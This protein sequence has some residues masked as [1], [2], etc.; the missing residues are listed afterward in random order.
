M[1]K[2]SADYIFPITS[3]PIKNGVV[4]VDEHGFILNVSEASTSDNVDRYEGIICPGFVNTHCHLELSHMRSQVSEQLGMGG[5]IKEIISKRDSFSE[6]E[7]KKAIEIAEAEMIT[8]GIVAVGDISNEALTFEQKAKGNIKYH[9]FIE[10]FDLHP[11]KAKDVFERAIKHRDKLS[12][13]S[14][15]NFQLATS[16]VPHAPYTVTD[17]LFKL[18]AQEAIKSNSI[19]CIHNQESLA[20]SEFYM[21]H[22]GTIAESFT[23]MGIDLSYFPQTGLNSLQTIFPKLPLSQKIL[24]VH[25]TYTT[26]EDIVFAQNSKL[27]T[28]DLYWCT[29]PNANL[30]IENKL[31]NY[32]IFLKHN[33]TVTIGT[34]SLA[35]NKRLSVLDELK[36][37]TKHYPKI[38]LETLLLWAT[39]NGA[40]YLG[41][42]QLGSIEKGKQPGLNLLSNIENGALTN[43]TEVVKLI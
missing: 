25:N 5:F 42:H 24:L 31:P 20:E 38:S 29:C 28:P 9:T 23:K 32:D 13:L 26:E 40:D 7:I 36:T 14:T 10:V 2:I 16:I 12:E 21:T 17:T 6:Q 33:C 8:N 19:V 1:R 18:I 37:I 39:K 27:Q 15:F 35:S 3:A 43:K 22:T 4:E 34:D 30:Y 41:F 11:A